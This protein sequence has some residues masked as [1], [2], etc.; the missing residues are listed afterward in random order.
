MEDNWTKTGN[1]AAKA[2][3]ESRWSFLP[4]EDFESLRTRLALSGYI[5]YK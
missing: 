1:P 4:D 3:D 5:E 2:A